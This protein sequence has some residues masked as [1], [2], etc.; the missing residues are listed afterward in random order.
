MKSSNKSNLQ[1]NRTQ[2]DLCLWIVSHN[3]KV[4]KFRLTYLRIAIALVFF[5]M[6]GG[7]LFLVAGDYTRV[8]LLRLKNY[9]LLK[10]IQSERDT[11]AKSKNKLED[12][13]D[14][15]KS[16]NLKVM[17][18]ERDIKAKLNELSAIVESATSLGV[19]EEG[20]NSDS[21]APLEG[22]IGGA[23]ID[24]DEA[25]L[26]K[27]CGQILSDASPRAMLNPLGLLPEN[28]LAMMV[29]PPSQPILHEEENLVQTLDRYI[30]FMRELPMG[31][32][33]SGKLS[34]GYGYRISPFSGHLSLHE[35]IDISL[36]HGE[37][38]RSSGIGVVKSVGKNGTYGLLVDVEHSNRVVTRYAHLSKIMVSEG[39]K[40]KVG[41]VIGLAGS[42]GRSTG[43][44]LHYEV[45]VEGRPKNPKNF[46][47]LVQKIKKVL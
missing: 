43:P 3:A 22:G 2:R 25:F 8:Q 15:L 35:G 40:I 28:K 46:L 21:A 20:Q 34:S 17:E 1:Y 12:E 37:S 10:K 47:S 11:L 33:A 18:Y 44:H 14:N 45:R 16:A 42:T 9:V 19:V 4:R 24:C 32:P 39:D 6:I 27:A 29:T 7:G 23:E 30:S 26:G 38:I 36:S 5:T 31:N 13:L 41:D